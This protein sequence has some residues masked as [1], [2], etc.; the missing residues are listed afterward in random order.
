MNYKLLN[1][2]V[3][4]IEDNLTSD[5]DLKLLAK[6][7]GLNTFIMERVFSIVSNISIKEYIRK[8]RLSLAYEEIK[9]TNNKIIDIALKYGYDSSISFA[10]SFKKEFNVAPNKVR[11]DKNNVYKTFLK[12]NFNYDYPYSDVSSFTVEKI[13]D[14]NLYVDEISSFTLDDLHYKIR[15]LYEKIKD[16]KTYDFLNGNERYAVFYFKNKKYYYALGS[17][18]KDDNK[19][20]IK[21][22][23]EKYAIFKTNSLNQKDILKTYDFINKIWKNSSKFKIINNLNIEEYKDGS[24]YIYVPIKN[25]F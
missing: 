22:D 24:C 13:E 10:R 25:D 3:D 6:E 8:R 15:K 14:F 12:I 23:K 4:Y 18:R 20:K 1:K 16:D 9:S 5:I 11:K 21:I 19:S 7:L 2:I 17:K